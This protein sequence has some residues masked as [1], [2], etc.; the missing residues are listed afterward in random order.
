MNEARRKPTTGRQPPSPFDKWP[1]IFYMPS[2]TDTAVHTKAFDY[3]VAEHWEGNQH[4]QPREDSNRQHSEADTREVQLY[5][6]KP[7]L[8]S[9][10]KSQLTVC[11]MNS[12][13]KE[14]KK[15]PKILNITVKLYRTLLLVFGA[16]CLQNCFRLVRD[17]ISNA[18][19]HDC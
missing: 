6:P 7:I 12:G 19:R 15:S 17:V 8:L 11:H 18:G 10:S 5:K 16:A 13:L 1:G 3:P 14:Y 4:V 2:L 9:S